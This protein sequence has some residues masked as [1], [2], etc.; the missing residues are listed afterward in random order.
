MAWEPK[1]MRKVRI[2]N[3]Q[4]KGVL[5]KLLTAVAEAGGNV[6]SINLLTETSRH[7]VRD[8]TITAE[9]EKS[10]AAV[11]AAMETNEGT[12]ILTP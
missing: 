3:S 6:G 12:K 8:I 4:K 2:R 7:V 9:D 5:G 1:I 11:L 10:L